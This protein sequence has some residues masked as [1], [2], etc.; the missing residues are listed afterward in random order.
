MSEMISNLRDFNTTTAVIRLILAFTLG[1]CIGFERGKRGRPAG[2]RTH[3]F[4]CMGAAMTV[5]VS[6][7]VV[8]VLGYDGDVFRVPAQVIS[9][10]GFL[11]VGTILVTGRT[12]VRGLT[13]AAGLWNAAIIG[14]VT[15]YG[16]Y[17]IAIVGTLLSTVT[18]GYLHNVEN[19]FYKTNKHFEVYLEVGSIDNVT[20]CVNRLNLE[21]Y[22]K[23]IEI[24]PP[25]SATS[26]NV[27]IE[28][29]VSLPRNST[30][31]QV[32]SKLNKIEGVLFALESK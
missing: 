21:F 1:G 19:N 22:S 16:F 3:V 8:N 18:I 13:T 25:R 11:G 12:H 5:L 4:I 15:G 10:I 20:N 23:N 30:K 31:E 27:G 9:G 7:Y 29:S 26:G 32:V 24:R 17:E 14:I 2:L 28:A 6:L